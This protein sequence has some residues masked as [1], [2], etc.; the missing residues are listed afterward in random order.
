MMITIIMI[1]T[2]I[3]IIITMIMIIK[4][5]RLQMAKNTRHH[6][7]TPPF[8]Y[9]HTRNPQSKYL[10]VQTSGTLPGAQGIPPLTITNLLES[11]PLESRFSVRG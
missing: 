9:L 6:G 4:V 11:S 10:R 1:I 2:I 5:S 7:R 8:P 3:T